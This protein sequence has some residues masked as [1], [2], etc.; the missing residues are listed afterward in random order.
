[1]IYLNCGDKVFLERKTLSF[2]ISGRRKVAS[3]Y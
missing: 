1:M 3:F 2:F